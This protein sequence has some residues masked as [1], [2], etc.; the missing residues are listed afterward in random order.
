MPRSNKDEKKARGVICNGQ[1]SWETEMNGGE[2]ESWEEGLDSGLY[3][4]Y[5]FSKLPGRRLLSAVPFPKILMGLPGPKKL[6]FIFC[7]IPQKPIRE[8][9]VPCWPSWI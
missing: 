6:P 4:A 7:R 3:E 8:A 1:D 9:D 2:G 5:T